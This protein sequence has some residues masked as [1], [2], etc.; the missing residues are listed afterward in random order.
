[1]GFRKSV[2]SSL[3]GAPCFWGKEASLEAE[4]SSPYAEAPPAREG[5]RPPLLPP[6][7]ER[8]CKCNIS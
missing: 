5:L 7:P 8:K 1:M 4:T 6:S 3:L 2:L